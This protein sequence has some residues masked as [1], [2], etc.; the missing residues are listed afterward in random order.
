MLF[1]RRGTN[2][3][4][5][6]PRRVPKYIKGVDRYG[7]FYRYKL[8]QLSPT[9]KMVKFPLSPTN[10]APK[11]FK[12]VP[13]NT[14]KK[15]T[16]TTATASS[17]VI[18]TTLSSSRSSQERW[19]EFLKAWWKEN[20]AVL[21]LNFGSICTLV[22]FTRSDVL[23]LRG[24]SVTGNICFISYQLV[25]TPV[26]W[27]PIGYSAL[28][29]CVNLFKIGQIMNERVGTVVFKSQEEQDTYE[30][31]FQPHGVTP[32]QFQYISEKATIAKVSKGRPLMLQ[33]NQP[34]PKQVCLVVEGRTMAQNPLGRRL[35]AV[36]TAHQEE[37]KGGDSGAWIGDMAFLEWL[38]WIENTD[39]RKR[40][41]R[42]LSRNVEALEPKQDNDNKDVEG[43]EYSNRNALYSIITK[44]DCTVLCWSYEDMAALYHKSPDLRAA[45]TRSMTAALVGKVLNFAISRSNVGLDQYSFMWRQLFQSSPPTTPVAPQ[46]EDGDVLKDEE[47]Q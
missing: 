30:R 1:G 19:K 8:D 47:A 22:G 27:V 14:A 39:K 2:K 26:R 3:K 7:H 24:L 13:T 46:Q 42:R 28:F 33:I 4:R 15:M 34:I 36:S 44:T 16:E 18:S 43:E 25:Q 40:Q 11:Q 5:N 6:R 35:T 20:W 37:K 38:H 10:T 31:H 32:K 12:T 17:S 29:A 21:V 23:E 41:K 45:L 9:S